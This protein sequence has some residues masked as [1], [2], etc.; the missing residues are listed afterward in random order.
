M[1]WKTFRDRMGAFGGLM[2]IPGL[3]VIHGLG[4]VV[5]PE[6]VIGATIAVWT[7]M[8]QFYFRKATAGEQTP[9]P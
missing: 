4:V 1:G 7:L 9:T 8:F 6:T 3:W 2:L 5:L